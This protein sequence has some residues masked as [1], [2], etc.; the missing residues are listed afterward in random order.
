MRLGDLLTIIALVLTFDLAIPGIG[1]FITHFYWGNFRRRILKLWQSENLRYEHIG[2]HMDEF[3]YRF[4]GH[5]DGSDKDGF[6]HL[7]NEALSILAD[8]SKTDVFL[9][10]EGEGL[11]HLERVDI[12]DIQAL[13]DVVKIF[14]GGPINVQDGRLVFCQR[15]KRKPVI[16]LYSGSERLMFARAAS[17]GHRVHPYLNKF[18][19]FSI[20]FGTFLLLLLT[21]KFLQ[22]PGMGQSIRL[23]L[24]AILIPVYPILPP[25]ILSLFLYITFS[26]K[27]HQLRLEAEETIE[28]HGDSPWG[29]SE[30]I[31]YQKLNH[32]ASV[33]QVLSVVMTIV[34]VGINAIIYYQLLNLI[35]LG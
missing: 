18:T 22:E 30:L 27:A 34:A 1:V 26:R 3:D 14:A 28:S 8:P 10:P 2:E 12:R 9:L 20:G 21:L 35:P 25:G 24:S 23:G 11:L 6:I 13:G 19:P 16:L 33:L 7:R 4:I 15:E 5:Y 17:A 29:G 32:Q 31:Q